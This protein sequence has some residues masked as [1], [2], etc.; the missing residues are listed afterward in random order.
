MKINNNKNK[1]NN[2]SKIIQYFK[3]KECLK[4]NIS[5][6]KKALF[7]KIYNSSNTQINISNSINSSLYNN[8]N[9]NM[10]KFKMNKNNFNNN[11]LINQD[12]NNN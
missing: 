2:Q 3:I 10:N 7:Y 1:L 11:K 4:F 12:K 6:N 5:I 8:I 9:N